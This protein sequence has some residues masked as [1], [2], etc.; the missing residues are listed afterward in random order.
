M[1]HMRLIVA[2]IGNTPS[3][4]NSLSEL[5]SDAVDEHREGWIVAS[6]F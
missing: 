6:A 1:G 2:D 4:R 5:E 3:G